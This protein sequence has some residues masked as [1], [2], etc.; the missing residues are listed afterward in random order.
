MEIHV[1]RALQKLKTEDWPKS[2]EVLTV[3][4]MNEDDPQTEVTE[5]ESRWLR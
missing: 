2:G 3:V 1:A 5:Y 4:A